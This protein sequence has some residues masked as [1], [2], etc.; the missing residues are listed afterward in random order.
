MQRMKTQDT[1][2]AVPRA[3]LTRLL[4]SHEEL[5]AL[6]ETIDILLDKNA[7]QSLRRAEGDA[8]AGRHR[9]AAANEVRKVLGL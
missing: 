2:V 5:D 4:K 9:D 6:L 7:T 1:T 3:L 8:R